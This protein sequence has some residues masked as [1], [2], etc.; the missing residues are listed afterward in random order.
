[1][2]PPPPSR[3][4]DSLTESEYRSEMNKT[5][6][7]L[8]SCD[9]AFKIYLV[10]WCTNRANKMMT[11]IGTPSNHNR[12]PRPMIISILRCRPIPAPMQKRFALSKVRKQDGNSTAVS[13]AG[14]G[15]Q[16]N[17]AIFLAVTSD[18]HAN[19]TD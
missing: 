13:L 12:I 6:P 5:A 15:N 7:Q 19:L 8:S 9:A 3:T 4:A 2:L 11:G 18:C 10:Q 16:K 1:M 14:I 17:D